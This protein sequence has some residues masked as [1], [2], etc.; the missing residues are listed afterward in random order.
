MT[1]L[2]HNNAAQRLR[3]LHTY[4][5]E[6]VAI[7]DFDLTIHEANP[8]MAQLLAVPVELKS[9]C[10][11]KQYLPAD[12]VAPVERALREAEHTGVAFFE[13]QLHNAAGAQLHV[14]AFGSA[15][16][17][18]GQLMVKMLVRDIT[19]STQ[20]VAEIQK[21][22]RRVVHILE[23]TTDAYV[24]VDHAWRITYINSRGEA[25]FKINRSAALGRRLWDCFPELV[26]SFYRAFRSA[27]GA[28]DP[29]VIEGHYAAT[30]K[31][32]EAHIYPHIDG[33]S[34][35]LRDVSAR[36]ATEEQLRTLARFP[37]ENPSPVLRISSDGTLTYRNAASNDLMREWQSDRGKLV[38]ASIRE[39]V[40][41]A[42]ST[43]APIELELRA[44]DRVYAM[45]LSPEPDGHYVNAYG[46]DVTARVHAEEQLRLHRDHLEELVEV[47]THDLEM[48]RDEAQQANR[49]KSAFLANMSHELR[50]PLNAII[51]Y[52][53]ILQEDATDGGQTQAAADLTKIHSAAHHLLRLIN[54][55]LDLSKIEA[56]RMQIETEEFSV[57]NL[58]ASAVSTIQPL[59]R[60]NQNRF[61]VK[62]DE[63]LGTMVS[64]GTRLRQCLLNLLS[65]ACKFT[66][67]GTVTL[68]VTRHQADEEAWLK[69]CVQDTGI[70]MD[71]EQ[72]S[73]LFEAFSQVHLQKGKFG[74]TGLGLALTKHLCRMM[75]GD[76]TVESEPGKGSQFTICLPA[77]ARQSRPRFTQF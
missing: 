44:H 62:C 76:V 54:D 16:T 18:S 28:N 73:R 19:A 15:M 37:D 49:A 21:V 5:R 29:M 20:A 57:A 9:G 6:A 4:A 46:R 74:G 27:M 2:E 59:A 64:D 11:L 40:A 72:Q 48:A 26:S 65:N 35:Y 53:E 55:V 23:S 24:A 1:E 22:N 3:Q 70:G 61:V 75:G 68:T 25:L 47:R 38:P 71:A 39:E 69:F 32:L 13:T 50:T 34:T 56:G 14:A 31:W 12:C 52:T 63:D 77:V 45:L 30:D 42:L 67:N 43:G 10:S 17:M 7:V 60:A 58:V 41:R 33:L 51:G 66:V 8:A 36:R